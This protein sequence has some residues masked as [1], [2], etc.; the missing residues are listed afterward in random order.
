[1]RESE[2][3][4]ESKRTRAWQTRMSKKREIIL[5]KRR[6]RRRRRRKRRGKKK[7]NKILA[8]ARGNETSE[9]KLLTRI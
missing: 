6:K 4:R 7:K 9:M 1:M 2:R 3:E 5:K 8:F